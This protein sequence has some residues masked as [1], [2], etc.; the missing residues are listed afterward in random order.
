MSE[1]LRDEFQKNHTFAPQTNTIKSINNPKRNFDQF[2]QDQNRHIQKAKEK[3]NFFK[4]EKKKIEVKDYQKGP[5][6]NEV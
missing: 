1:K 3:I 6:I 2:L 5:T 4:E